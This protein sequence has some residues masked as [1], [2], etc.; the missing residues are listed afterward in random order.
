M[1]KDRALG[2]LFAARPRR[3]LEH[4]RHGRAALQ[5]PRQQDRAVQAA[6]GEDDEGPGHAG[7]PQL[8]EGVAKVSRAAAFLE[9]GLGKVL[10][11]GRA[12]GFIRAGPDGGRTR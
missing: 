2:P 4:E 6:A 3:R 8:M 1:A 10:L 5:R 9:Y 11:E 12:K 7:R